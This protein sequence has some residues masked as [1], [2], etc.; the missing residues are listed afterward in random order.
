MSLTQGSGATNEVVPFSAEW[1]KS[2]EAVT[3][4]QVTLTGDVLGQG[5]GSITTVLSPTIKNNIVTLNGTVIPLGGTYVMDLDDIGDV[6]ITSPV[7]DQVLSYSNGTW[8]NK[9]VAG[10]AGAITG[11]GTAGRVAYWDGSSSITSSSYFTYDSNGADLVVG[12]IKLGT[13]GVIGGAML[14]HVD[15]YTSSY[16]AVQQDSYGNTYINGVKPGTP[17]FDSETGPEATDGLFLRLGNDRH[18]EYNFDGLYW[19]HWYDE[20]NKMSTRIR[21]FGRFEFHVY[22]EVPT[23]ADPNVL[24]PHFYFNG[25]SYHDGSVIVENVGSGAFN[26]VR[27]GSA[28]I[29]KVLIAK[30]DENG[31]PIGGDSIGGAGFAYFDYAPQQTCNYLTLTQYAIQQD[32][33][34]NTYVNAATGWDPE[35]DFGDGAEYSGRLYLRK[36]NSSTRQL[37]F[38]GAY[39]THWVDVDNKMSTY[40]NDYGRFEF[41]VYGEVPSGADPNVIYPHFYYNGTSYHDGSIIVENVGPGAFNYVRAGSAAISKVQITAIDENGLPIGGDPIGGAGFAYFDYAPG[42]TCNYLTTTQYAVQQDMYGNTYVNAAT[43]WDPAKN[44]GS[45]GTYNGRLYLRRGNSS[46]RQ[47]AFDGSYWTHWLN[48]T[49]KMSTY[50]NTNGRFDFASYG[51]SPGF[52]FNGVMSVDGTITIGN[53][54]Y[55]QSGSGRFGKVTVVEPIGAASIGGAGLAY[56]DAGVDLFTTTKYAIQQDSYGNTYLN[57]ATVTGA[58]YSGSLYLRK[59]NSSTNQLVFD[60]TYWT[61]WYDVDRKMQTTML[62]D[63][64]YQMSVYNNLGS[65]KFYFYGNMETNG[66]ITINDDY[67][68]LQSGRAKVGT[69]FGPGSIAGAAFAHADNFTTTNYA[70]Q[71]Y[72]DG[73]TFINAASGRAIYF[74]INNT[75]I[76]KLVTDSNGKRL[77]IGTHPEATI[78]IMTNTAVPNTKF[79]YDSS[80]YYTIS[81]DGANVVAHYAHNAAGKF[82][83]N[84]TVEVT[85]NVDLATGSAFKINGTN[86]LTATQVLGKAVPTGT[87]VGTTDSQTLTNKTLQS[88]VLTGTLTANSSTGTAGQVLKSTGSGVE[89]G[90]VSAGGMS[91]G[92]AISSSTI[93]SLL[94]VGASNDLQQDPNNLWWDYTNKRLYVGNSGYLISPPSRVFIESTTEQLRVAYDAENYYST[95]VASNGAVTFNAVGLG[96]KFTFSDNVE[97]PDAAYGAGWS[98]STQAPTKNAIYNKIQS[99][100]NGTVTQVSTGTGLTG[101]P[102][103]S[104]GT[105]SVDS[106]VV[107]T[108]TNFTLKGANTFQNSAGIFITES[109]YAD[110]I[111][112]QAYNSGTVPPRVLTLTNASLTATRTITFPNVTGT[113]ITTGDTGT[114]TN[115]MLAGSI[116]NSKLTNSSITVNGSSIALGGSATVTANTA[117]NFTLKFDSGTSEGTDQ[118]VFNGGSA[119]SVNIVAGSNIILTKAS[120]QIT[121]AS[122]ASG[123]VTGSGT[124]TQLA[125]WSSSS[126]LTS[127]SNLYYDATNARLGVKTS[128]PLADLDVYGQAMVQG[129]TSPSNRGAKIGALNINNNTAD[130]TVDFTQ[131]LVFTN[132]TNNQ[133]A[134][135]HA[136]I[137]TVGSTG[138][139]GSLVFGTDGDGSRNTIGL[140]ERMRLTHDGKLGINTTLPLDT[141]EV[142]KYADAPTVGVTRVNGTVGSPTTVTSGDSYGAYYFRGVSSDTSV[143]PAALMSSIAES[144]PSGSGMAGNILL[145]TS[146]AVSPAVRWRMF[147]DGNVLQVN[148]ALSYSNSGARLHVISTTEPLRLGYDISN[149][150]N[151]AID[152]TGGMTIDG[153]G[154]GKGVKFAA[155]F[156]IGMFGATPTTQ[157]TTGTAGATRTGGGGTTVTDTDTFDGYTIAQVVKALRNLGVLA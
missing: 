142:R 11:S 89:W 13:Q 8:I 156:K 112:I 87:I 149:Y 3:Q 147:K 152:A 86:V 126:A 92:G 148:S 35:A 15:N 21:D 130:D 78:H 72:L 113:V 24:Y 154:T 68:L 153:A 122:T 25:T 69:L 110:G 53:N 59:N 58:P 46:S 56:S 12:N 100:G 129:S 106:T 65:S 40:M 133:G 79:E 57:A 49:T 109:S 140:V 125:Y 18:N 99:M 44:G 74:Q 63:G 71:Q 123:G 6:T 77:G 34:G 20:A 105:I 28:A 76:A 138:Y 157:F 103:T 66:N 23:G 97:V 62:S 88:A 150:S 42:H 91:I 17:G 116:A 80:N 143:Y 115:T 60:G 84:R 85:G 33:Y 16:Y 94:Y 55:L 67:K 22:G 114:V 19:T 124:A 51:S 4:G 45:G 145:W 36:D 5:T 73:T 26:Y 98:G 32:M 120:G 41:H 118:Y 155:G 47:L 82:T 61:H 121:I 30:I 27:A 83:F 52:Y 144:S 111:R 102:I 141:L 75:D 134:W 127:T 104:T 93:R 146:N 108:E 101:G 81:S 95:T 139:N 135:T 7:N 96:S 9:T 119:K 2:L 137:T 50:L 117:N 90:T 29:S 14:A 54:G 43:G 131:G 132:N 39:W 64:T 151:F 70:I 136:A 38:D 37:T 10:G 31:L 48:E 107:T 128:S 1:F